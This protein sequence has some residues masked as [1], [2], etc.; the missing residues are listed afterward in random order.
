MDFIV[1]LLILA[2]ALLG[3]GVIALIWVAN[4]SSR[5]K[6]L[7]FALR[8]G[9]YPSSVSSN[10]SARGASVATT[11]VAT[12]SATS[13]T[14]TPALS[15]ISIP[16]PPRPKKLEKSG[17]D[18]FEQFFSWMARDWYLKLGAILMLLAVIW[19]VTYAFM[20]NWIGESGRI[21]LGLIAGV[22]VMV[23]AQWWQTRS[24]T[25]S[26]V[27]YGLGAAMV[28][29]TTWAARTM[30]D[31]FTPT[32][33]L[34]GMLLVVLTVAVS[35][36][37]ANTQS[38]AV[39]S[40]I[41]AAFIPFLVDSGTNDYFGLL[42][43]ALIITVAFVALVFW[44]RWQAVLVV[45]TAVIM[46][47]TVPMIIELAQFQSELSELQQNQV[48]KSKVQPDQ[49]Y[50]QQYGQEISFDD[51]ISPRAFGVDAYFSFDS[52]R[53]VTLQNRMRPYAN[54]W[55]YLASFTMLLFTGALYL[56][57]KERKITAASLIF[58]VFLGVYV[59]GWIYGT[60]IL[61]LQGLAATLAAGIFSVT[62]F[63][64]ARQRDS[65]KEGVVLLF[66]A[67]GLLA[68][69]AAFMLD[70]PALTISLMVLVATYVAGGTWLLGASPE[71]RPLGFLYGLTTLLMYP[72]LTNQWSQ[73]KPPFEDWF[74]VLIYVFSVTIA[75]YLWKYVWQAGQGAEKLR[76]L[77]SYYLTLL[78]T[79]MIFWARLLD[80]ILPYNA[81]GARAIALT[82]F[83]AL[84]IVFY[85]R[86]RTKNGPVMRWT[87]IA[88]VGG[89]TAWLLL[90]ETGQMALAT[91]II[92]FFL[93]GGL[94][95]G[96]ALVEKKLFP[97]AE[98]AKG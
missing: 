49:L 65:R 89:T 40:V 26:T 79:L 74:V 56:L 87:G 18:I 33:A 77:S 23:F 96:V 36:A 43:Y 12:T 51:D 44:K 58:L 3:S 31:M 53:I 20:N 75:L 39:L 76:W 67:L 94:F 7:E 62:A 46:V 27:L 73:L 98:E 45:I 84:G 68:A 8:S 29:A 47:Y 4:L 11:E 16:I 93:V 57:S 64:V 50:G 9:E 48:S 25:Q 71:S 86:G 91:R 54:L 28:L 83:A 13:Q 10:L 37:M 1:I 55:V 38:R 88:L 17:P 34:V 82:T 66:V 14:V 97:R 19:F 72:H 52:Q 90:V 70:G 24:M 81:T 60:V 21:A 92:T 59:I 61:Q 30:F 69:A 95:I 42:R 80:Y 5:V 63:F 78:V 15:A 41:T 22:G 2:V 35:S 85:L 32:T 6:K